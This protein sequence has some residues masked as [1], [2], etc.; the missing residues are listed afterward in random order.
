MWWGCYLVGCALLVVAG[1]AKAVHPGDTAR[2][3]AQSLGRTTSRSGRVGWWSAGVRAAAALEAL[4]GLVAAAVPRP[5]TAGLVAASYAV[6]TGFVVVARHR[7][8]PLATCGCFGQPDTPPTL[9]HVALDAGFAL[10]ALAVALRVP[11]GTDLV[12]LLGRSPLHGVP[13]VA[14]VAVTSW[15]ALVAMTALARVGGARAELAA[16]PMR[17]DGHG[18]HG[19][20]HLHE[21][22]DL[23]P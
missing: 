7:G 23:R 8:G 13:M 21:H 5:V 12:T 9:V 1:V 18:R 16:V 3:L 4:L 15:L 6:F 10:A 22:G 19:E 14:A 17:H 20:G 11:A 2:A